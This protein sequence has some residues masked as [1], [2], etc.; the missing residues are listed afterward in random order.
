[1]RNYRNDEQ[2]MAVFLDEELKVKDPRTFTELYSGLRARSFLPKI[3]GINATD[4]TYEYDIWATTGEA[5]FIGEHAR[6]LPIIEVGRRPA[7]VGLR[8]VAA[9][10][11]WSVQTIRAAMRLGKPVEELTQRAAAV[12]IMRKADRLLAL[13]DAALGVTGLAND[14]EIIA[15]NNVTPENNFTGSN[16]DRLASLNKL[17][18]TTFG[19][20]DQS[21]QFTDDV[22]AFGQLHVIMPPTEYFYCKSTPYSSTSS[23]SI[24]EVFQRNWGDRVSGVSDW[25]VLAT[26]AAGNKPRAIAMP[27]DP[28]AVGAPVAEQEFIREQAQFTDLD[29]EVPVWT[30]VGAPV[31]RYKMAISYMQLVA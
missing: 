16:A 25:S 18:S 14:A 28:M 20:L 4:R 29:V 7:T 2:E 24:L 21:S 19:R 17:V 27:V 6:D 30:T 22:P 11:R 23:D 5:K 9:K 31:L 8:P 13:G 1:M 15:N 26:V 10:M 12:S 3:P